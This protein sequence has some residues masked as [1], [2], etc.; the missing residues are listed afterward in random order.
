M[1]LNSIL[2]DEKWKFLRQSSVQNCVS[3][4]SGHFSLRP[5]GCLVFSLW[6]QI[7]YVLLLMNHMWLLK[8]LMNGVWVWIFLRI[9]YLCWKNLVNI[10]LPVSPTYC[11]PHFLHVTKYTQF[12]YCVTPLWFDLKT[13]FLFVLC[14]HIHSLKNSPYPSVVLVTSDYIFG[15]NQ[16]VVQVPVFP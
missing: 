6:I 3:M 1:S 8:C 14:Y 9:L 12:L 7:L 2:M 11:L 4:E 16:M 15:F 13:F 10:V 5:L